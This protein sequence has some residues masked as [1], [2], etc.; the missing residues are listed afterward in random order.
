MWQK[1]S[2]TLAAIALAIAGSMVLFASPP[3]PLTDDAFPYR[4]GTGISLPDA[5]Y[6]IEQKIFEYQSDGLTP[7]TTT[8][9]FNNGDSGIDH[10]RLN[11]TIESRELYYPAKADGTRQLKAKATIGLDGTTYLTDAAFYPDGK[12]QR[13]GL[14]RA[15]K[16][17]E[18]NSYFED[19]I[20][21][22]INQVIG[23]KGEAHFEAILRLNGTYE[24]VAKQ[25]ENS[26]DIT[27]YS[28]E[29]KAVKTVS[30]AQY[31]TREITYYADGK[32]PKTD[33]HM[34]MYRTTASYFAPD[35][36]PTQLREFTNWQM[37]VTIF[38]D[39]VPSYRQTWRLLNTDAIKPEQVR[40]YSLMEAAVL[41]D[42]G[43]ASW[44][45]TYN[46]TTGKPA[47]IEIGMDKASDDLVSPVTRKWYG[48][49]GYLELL[50]VKKGEYGAEV[51]RQV[52]T[53]ADGIKP[54]AVP[55]YLTEPV[56]Y[57]VPPKPV[58]PQQPSMYH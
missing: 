35:G 47:M 49:E 15:D 42:A 13:E 51:S 6:A 33:F 5:K 57:E 11:G 31:W 10:H 55:A 16:A 25:N 1:A 24:R 36:K 22:H 19:G 21:L 26:F 34:E 18:I 58:P 41:N 38:K 17:Y 4:I 28:G 46:W 44:R 2:L 23:P 56:A 14:L 29:G 43:H 50:L 32:T 20:H 40:N 53:P 52:F 30:R 9:L 54:D 27:T 48:T 37:V 12:R 3:V 39:G 7:K 8:L 45:V